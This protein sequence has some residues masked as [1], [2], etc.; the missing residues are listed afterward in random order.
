LMSIFFFIPQTF[1]GAIG[2]PSV[3]AGYAWSTG[4]D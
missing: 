3:R 4:V 1:V 2:Y